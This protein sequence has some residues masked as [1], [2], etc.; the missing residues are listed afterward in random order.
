[1]ASLPPTWLARFQKASYRRGSATR[2]PDFN[3]RDAIMI[4]KARLRPPGFL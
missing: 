2:L 4:G 3:L 1:M